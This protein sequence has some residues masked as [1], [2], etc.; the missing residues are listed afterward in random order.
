MAD[1]VPRI[2]DLAEAVNSDPAVM[3]GM[4]HYLNRQGKIGINRDLAEAQR[5]F[6][7]QADA[8]AARELE[9]MNIY[10]PVYQRN[11]RGSWNFGNA[12]WGQLGRVLAC[13]GV[14]AVVT[15]GS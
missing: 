14:A 4:I 13:L 15:F 6:N 2:G 7:A 5:R 3:Q 8:S 1:N 11:H 9:L 10:L 12:D